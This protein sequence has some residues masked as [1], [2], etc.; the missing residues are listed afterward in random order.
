MSDEL[1]DSVAARLVS[2]TDSEVR[3]NDRLDELAD[4]I[5]TIKHILHGMPGQKEDKGVV[6]DLEKLDE[7][8]TRINATMWPSDPLSMGKSGLVFEVRKLLNQDERQ[9]R[10]AERWWKGMPMI[11]I[12]VISTVGLIITNLDRIE[13]YFKKAFRS[14]HPATVAPAKRSKKR[15]KP[16]P[17]AP[18]PE[19]ETD[20]QTG[21][22]E[23]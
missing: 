20:G 9:E 12:A 16:R 2:L 22:G 17:P 6:G 11:I 18:P 14:S 10:R 23:Q 7:S 19:E 3:Q 8:V 21:S 5:A 1:K 13:P 4:E 15:V